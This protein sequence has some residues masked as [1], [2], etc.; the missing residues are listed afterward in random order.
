MYKKPTNFIELLELQKVLDDKTSAPRTDGFIPRKRTE[1]D[2]RYALDD[3]FNEFM[4]E[5]PVELNFKTWKKK[6][7]SAEKQLEEFVDC[8]FFIA[9][10]INDYKNKASMSVEINWLQN[11][12][13]EYSYFYKSKNLVEFIDIFKSE[14]NGSISLDCYDSIEELISNYFSLSHKLG[15]SKNDLLNAYWKKWNKNMGR[16]ENGGDWN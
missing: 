3:E 11:T 14:L 10:A 6:E 9:A 16:S 5:L 2:L 12:L 13:E 4:K 7:W 1:R 15:Y 8:L